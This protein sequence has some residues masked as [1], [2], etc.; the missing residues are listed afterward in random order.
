MESIYI[1]EKYIESKN[2]RN[3]LSPKRREIHG[4]I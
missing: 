4:I 3:K 1:K 2:R